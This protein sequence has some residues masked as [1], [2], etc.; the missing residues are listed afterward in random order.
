MAG[1]LEPKLRWRLV[2]GKASQAA[3][4][5]GLEGD[6]AAC[7]KALD[8]LYDRD[9]NLARRG[10]RRAGQ[11][12]SP[13]SVVD[14]IESVHRLFPKETIERLEREAVEKYQVH[15]LVTHPAVLQ[16]VKPSVHLL[17][18]VL[19]TR[20]LMNQQVLA[21][22]RELVRRV[23]EQLM[24]KL[25][26]EI[27]RS[28]S[29]ARRWRRS[30]PFRHSQDLDFEATIR[31]NLKHYDPERQRLVVEKPYFFPHSRRHRAPWQ[32]ILLVDQSGSIPRHI[33]VGAARSVVPIPF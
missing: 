22:A 4:G 8:W 15:D 16:R 14:W 12:Q 19:K 29:G 7:E 2:L 23:V 9:E 20:H 6:A 18:A 25:A 21:L 1:E 33:L 11:E 24:E 30:S 26:R 27:Q 28:F 13:L 10:V 3:L 17:E 5:C 31:A 32:V